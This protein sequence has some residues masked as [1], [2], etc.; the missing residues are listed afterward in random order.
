M[1]KI[2]MAILYDGLDMQIEEIKIQMALSEDNAEIMD[3]NLKLAKLIA[4]K[5][6][7]QKYKVKPEQ[8]FQALVKHS[9]ISCSIEFRTVQYN[10]KQD[11]V[12]CIKSI[13]QIKGLTYPFL[14]F[15]EVEEC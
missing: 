4:V 14:F 12:D 15:C 10:F 5:N 1:R 11:V 9:R 13:F 7:Q 2:M 6:E 8:L 3:L